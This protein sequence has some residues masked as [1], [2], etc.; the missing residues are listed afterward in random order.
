MKSYLRIIKSSILLQMKQSLAREMYRFCLIVQPIVYIIIM[1]ALYSVSS[2]VNFMSFVV[3]GTGM[4]TLWSTIAF[5]SAGDLDR[6]R[7]M[8]TLKNIF[9]APTDYR[10]VV[11][12]KALGNTILGILPMLVLMVF[13]FLFRQDM[14]FI[15]HSIWFFI[16]LVETLLSF[17]AMSLIFSALFT[18]SRQTRLFMNC[19]E[20][21]I[22]ILCGI[23]FPVSYLPKPIR[24]LSYLLAPTWSVDL[25]K[26]TIEG[27]TDWP[28]FYGKIG[29]LIGLSV[30]YLFLSYWLF[31][32]VMRRV[33]VTAS[34]EVS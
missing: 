11:F 27:I 29:I 1:Y 5:S 32:Y 15:T 17:L 4:I 21:P 28:V 24:I 8:G 25:L 2:G 12:S 20:Y 26:S 3:L 23:V 6:E 9:A 10:L 22:Y 19:M 34:M 31:G 30:F 18:L 13:T 33:R 14:Y 16:V 7:R